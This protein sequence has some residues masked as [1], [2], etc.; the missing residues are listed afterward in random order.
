MSEL[1]SISYKMHVSGNMKFTR[2]Y[3]HVH[4]YYISF[5]GLVYE[6]YVPRSEE[7]G[8]TEYSREPGPTVLQYTAIA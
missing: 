8:C 4:M 5:Y 1:N 7:V 2:G 6:T 3:K